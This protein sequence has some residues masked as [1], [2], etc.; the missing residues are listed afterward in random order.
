MARPH[1]PALDQSPSPPPAAAITTQQPMTKRDVRRNR[2]MERL[3]QM[4]DS[5]SSN[6]HAHYR[7]QLQAVQVDMTLVLR[8]DPYE[9]GPLADS[10][11]EVKALIEEV[12]GGGAGLGGEGGEAAERDFAAM[13]GRRYK[14]FAGEVN[15]CLEKRDAELTSLHDH[16]H[17]SLRSLESLTQHKLH[18]AS[19]EH[20]A[21]SATIRQ[22]LIASLT[23]KR[24]NLLRDK[25]QL[26]IADSNALLLHPS[27]FSINNPGSPGGT[28]QQNR[29]TRHL[30]HRAGSPAPGDIG[31]DKGGEGNGGKKKRKAGAMEDENGNGNESPA[32]P[33]QPFRLPPPPDALGGGRSP[34]KDAREK[35]GYAQFEAPAYSLERI[36]TEKELAMATAT[37]QH[38]TYRYFHTPQAQKETA[39]EGQT[40]SGSNGTA[41]PSVDGQ[42]GMLP[43]AAATEGQQTNEDGTTGAHPT[44]ENVGTPPP[45]QPTPAPAAQEMERSTSHQVLTR[46]TARANPLAALSDLAA[47]AATHSQ[48]GASTLT[49]ENPFAPVIP[50]YH[51][52]SRSDKSFAGAPTPSGVGLVEGENDFEMMRRSGHH[53]HGLSNGYHNAVAGDPEDL[54]DA[55]TADDAAAAEDAAAA[56]GGAEMR[57]QLLDQALGLPSITQ[58]YRLPLIDSGPAVIGRGVDRPNWT[59]FSDVRVYE[60]QRMRQ[61]ITNFGAG[62]GGSGKD[63]SGGAGNSGGGGAGTAGSGSLAAALQGRIAA[64]GEAMSRTTSTGN[65]SEMGEP[66]ATATTTTST[67][68]GGR[69]RLV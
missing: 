14:E 28:A 68:R 26:D 20:A 11:D 1:T 64:G 24:Q 44:T 3:N 4:M 52:V 55:A 23:K 25:E 9:S 27:H 7:A 34:F 37:A 13:A 21:L 66:S 36:F 22:R 10:G 8:A 42:E 41:V 2:I 43:D 39:T 35:S 16:Y 62:G 32:P 33:H 30:R 53:H 58:P 19:E 46:G 56:L 45:S 40:G 50:S 54:P 5:F 31:A 18:Q 59:G 69:G 17:A 51:A 48:G 65:G 38:A 29:K 47:A 61:Q 63:G 6:Q 67:R 49:R 60:Q 57:R 12:T 15:D